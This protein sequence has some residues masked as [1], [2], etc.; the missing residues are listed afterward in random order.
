MINNLPCFCKY[1]IVKN[2]LK[3]QVLIGFV[4]NL[5]LACFHKAFLSIYPSTSSVSAKMCYKID[6]KI[7]KCYLFMLFY[8]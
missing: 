4:D 5:I 6:K 7:F 1:V 3:H 8:Y 2:E